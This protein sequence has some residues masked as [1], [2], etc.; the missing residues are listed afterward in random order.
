ML[1]KSLIALA[2]LAAGGA[3]AIIP[4]ATS[5]GATAL[6][7]PPGVT[8]PAYCT[9]VTVPTIAAVH[10]KPKKFKAANSGPTIAKVKVGTTISYRLNEPAIVTFRIY[11]PKVGHKKKK[12]GKTTCVK[13]APKKGQKKCALLV[14]VGS[15]TRVSTAGLNKIKFTGRIGGKKLHPGKYVL[16]P[17]PTASVVAGNTPTVKFKIVK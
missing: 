3:V 11:A 2:A 4:V 5:S 17:T 12:N 9:T 10:I 6:V 8:N 1:K 13:P 14:L 7:C 16:K 15:F